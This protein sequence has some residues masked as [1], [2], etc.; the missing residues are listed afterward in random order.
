MTREEAAKVRQKV[1]H[2]GPNNTITR[3]DIKDATPAGD[4]PKA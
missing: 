3:V 4:K 2:V 1:V